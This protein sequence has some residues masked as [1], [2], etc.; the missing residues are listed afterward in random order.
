MGYE[1]RLYVVDRR[2]LKNPVT[3]EV[4]MVYG[5]KIATFDMACVG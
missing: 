1:S 4:F 5:E 2:E 3:G